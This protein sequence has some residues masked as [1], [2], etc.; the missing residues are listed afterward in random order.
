LEQISKIGI[1]FEIRTNFKNGT[2]YGLEQISK[3]EID[4]EIGTNFEKWNKF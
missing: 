3:I 4:F 1:N 2:N